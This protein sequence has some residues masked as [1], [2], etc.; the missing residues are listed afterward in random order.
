MESFT[1]QDLIKE[2]QEYHQP[3][4]PRREGGVTHDE[5]AEAQGISEPAARGQL[6]R[7]LVRGILEREW[8]LCGDGERR[9][10]YYKR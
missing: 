3:A 10:V 4:A 9:F 5:W 7:L 2:L 8:S 6:K 1:T